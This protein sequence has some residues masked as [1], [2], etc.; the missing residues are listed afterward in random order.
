MEKI[1]TC[2]FA[3]TNTIVRTGSLVAK[4]PRSVL[5]PPA[6][7]AGVIRASST[8][9]LDCVNSISP[10]GP[11]GVDNRLFGECV[12]EAGEKH[13]ILGYLLTERVETRLEEELL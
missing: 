10:H 6:P 11:H 8:P 5:Q 12:N 4:M 2:V 7:N 3:G 13:N 9:S 1:S